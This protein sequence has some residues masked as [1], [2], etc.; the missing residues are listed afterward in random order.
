MNSL[1]L[2]KNK[3]IM[4]NRNKTLGL[5]YDTFGGSQIE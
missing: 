1:T 2:F 5:N 4:N 3:V